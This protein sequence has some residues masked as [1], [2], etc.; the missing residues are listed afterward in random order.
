MTKISIYI[1]THKSF[2]YDYDK[3]LFIPIL[4]GSA[5]HD[6]DFGYQRDDVGDNISN[7][8]EYYAELT[9]E[10][11]VWK[12]SDS[13]I[14]GFCHYRRYFAKNI[15][16]HNIDGSEINNILKDYDII[17][18]KKKHLSKSN[19]DNIREAYQNFGIGTKLEEYDKVREILSEFYPDY[20]NA[21]DD[22]LNSNGCYWYN[23]FICNKSLA[24]KYFEWLFDILKKMETRVNFDDYDEKRILGF[25][26]ERLLTVFVKKNNLKVKENFIIFSESK[27]PHISLI[28]FKFPIF[29]DILDSFKKLISK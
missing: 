25:L 15:L 7:L 11:W 20:L 26:S 17:L 5:S 10:Y 22:V 29:I 3:T 23:M 4:N 28:G 6:D 8:N 24:D 12:H 16:L 27:F 21:Y 1:L 13:D 9:G 19:I 14:V 2:D 18:P